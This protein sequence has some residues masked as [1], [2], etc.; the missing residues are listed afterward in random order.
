MIPRE[1]IEEIKYRND[2]VDVVSSYV[3]LKNAGSNMLGLCPFHSERTPSFTVFNSNQNYY[4]FGCGAGGDVITFIMKMENLDYTAALEFLAKR[5]GITIPAD[6]SA[7]K[8]KDAVDRQR[9][10]DMNRDAAKFFRNC[11]FDESIG[12]EAREYLSSRGLD[13]TTVKRFGLGYSPDSF[14]LLRDHMHRLGYTDEELTIG[15]LCGVSKKTGRSFDYFRNRVMFPIIEVSGN[16]V[17][18]GGRVMDGSMTKYLNT[19]DTPGFKKSRNRFA[20]NYAKNNCAEQMILC[21]GYMDVIA[22]H[23]AGFG[24]AVA[25]LGTAITQEQARIMS[26]YTKKVIISYDSDD[27]G[28][29]AAFKAMKYLAEVGL[30]VKIL[31]MDGAKD[32]DEYIK[33]FGADAFKKLLSE[34]KTS[35]EYKLD[36]VLSRYDITNNAE[37]IK[38]LSELC[39]IIAGVYSEVEREIYISEVS[40][41]FELPPDIIRNDVKRIVSKK[42]RERKKEE[43]KRAMAESSGWGDRINADAMKNVHAS[44][45]EEVILGL[46]LLYDDLRSAVYRRDVELDAEDFFTEFGRRVFV[47][48]LDGE[49]E[50]GFDFGM[51]GERFSPDE[52]GRITKIKLSREKLTQN[53]KEVL[54]DAAAALRAERAKQNLRES[55]NLLDEIN[56]IREKKKKQN[57]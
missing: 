13:S 53:N 29:A 10:F 42:I 46:M 17:A 14:N 5:A 47:A 4:C 54:V 45:T 12:K 40:R 52:I 48:V 30:D 19:A 56:N 41:R 23:A 38:A 8:K 49:K 34:S 25:T 24:N 11:L 9:V 27:A 2:I 51:L 28:K 16:V 35:F 18:F 36:D 20:L 32:P 7:P 33:K 39:A 55:G 44:K 57:K 3:T 1:I 43:G 22:L 31:K 50:G 26:R 21:E 6:T 37:K 15:F